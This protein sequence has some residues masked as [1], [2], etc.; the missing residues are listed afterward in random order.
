MLTT[1]VDSGMRFSKGVLTLETSVSCF[2]LLDKYF[3]TECK[4]SKV[5]PDAQEM[6]HLTV[7]EG[8]KVRLKNPFKAF[9]KQ[10]CRIL[11]QASRNSFGLF[12]EL[13]SRVVV[14]WDS[15]SPK[16]QD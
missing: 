15:W 10:D 8:N 16:S 4:T 3:L 2:H 12:F 1:G 7:L 14:T 13:F 9:A 5:N 6:F 11:S